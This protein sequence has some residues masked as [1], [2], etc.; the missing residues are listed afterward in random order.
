MRG[1]RLEW[2]G[3]G[4]GEECGGLSHL[5]HPGRY[6]K[7]PLKGSI[8]TFVLLATPELSL[9]LMCEGSEGDGV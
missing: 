8:E 3:S 2:C 5:L 4:M 7:T 9:T 1:V 6:I